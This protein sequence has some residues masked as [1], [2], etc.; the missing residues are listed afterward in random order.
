MPT[1]PIHTCVRGR[2]WIREI[3]STPSVSRWAAAE[4]GL[5]KALRAQ[6][7]RTEGEGG[8]R[9]ITQAIR[10]FRGALEIRTRE[11]L[12]VDWAATQTALGNALRIEGK[13]SSGPDGEALLAESAEALRQALKILTIEEMPNCGSWQ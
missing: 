5:G 7:E 9:L 12:P 13:R 11:Q 10:A 3:D 6:A 1:P 2:I 8:Q 4:N